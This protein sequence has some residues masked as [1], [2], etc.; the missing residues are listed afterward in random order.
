VR[1]LAWLCLLSSSGCIDDAFADYC[2]AHAACLADVECITG[3][4]DSCPAV[5]CLSLTDA[6]SGSYWIDVH[7]DGGSPQ[8]L[9]CDM[10]SDN[11]GWTLVGAVGSYAGS[12]FDQWLV[13]EHSTT[14]L[15]YSPPALPS[16]DFATVDA[17]PLAILSTEIRVS[18]DGPATRWVRW[19]LPTGR[20]AATLWQHDAGLAT[21]NAASVSPERITAV[22]ADGGASVCYQ[23]PTGIAWRAEQGGA[24]PATASDPTGLSQPG[25]DCLMIGT[26]AIGATADGFTQGD[27]GPGFDAPSNDWPNT[28]LGQPPQLMIWLR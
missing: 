28:Q 24:Y 7:Q 9:F 22:Q 11:G 1:R 10:D 15:G 8:F 12:D 20:T 25:D 3:T 27:G 19:P 13:T 4:Q 2:D 5:S 26:L 18:A 6:G 17:V 23:N 14:V 16:F 21:V